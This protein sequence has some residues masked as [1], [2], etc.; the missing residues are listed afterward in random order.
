VRLVVDEGEQVC[1]DCEGAL[2]VLDDDGSA[3]GTV[4]SLI[5]CVC[6]ALSVPPGFVECRACA[7]LI[8]V[9]D[10]S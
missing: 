3:S 2:V 9:P 4:G 6:V 7:S 5:D 10:R 1:P 8:S